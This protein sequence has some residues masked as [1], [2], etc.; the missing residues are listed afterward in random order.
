MEMH[1]SVLHD[2]R[3]H[4]L[5][6]TD[7]PLA[8]STIVSHF[9]TFDSRTER[10]LMELSGR[11]RGGSGEKGQGLTAISRVELIVEGVRLNYPRR[12]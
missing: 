9:S 12:Y 10:S 3:E 2:W 5:Y 1:F 7:H 8:Q 11:E 4:C 6:R